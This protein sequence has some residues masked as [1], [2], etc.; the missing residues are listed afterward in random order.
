MGAG[1][2][3]RL[4][5]PRGKPGLRKGLAAA[6]RQRDRPAREIGKT[7]RH[8]NLARH[9]FERPQKIEVL[10]AARPKIHEKGGLVL[11]LPRF[12]LRFKPQFFKGH[13]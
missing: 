13:R 1:G 9:D 3:Q 5:H 10:D 2:G 12:F 8:E 6:Q 7:M 11:R 4:D